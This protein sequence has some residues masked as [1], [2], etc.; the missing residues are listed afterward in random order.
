MKEFDLASG[1]AIV[2]SGI[3]VFNSLLRLCLG[4]AGDVNF[5]A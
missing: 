5:A 1:G 2:T 3:D 4:A